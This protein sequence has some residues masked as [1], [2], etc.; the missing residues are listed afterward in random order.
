LGKER[1]GEGGEEKKGEGK[2]K[3]KDFRRFGF[4][5]EKLIS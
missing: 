1:K 2:E 4:W 5:F 3:G